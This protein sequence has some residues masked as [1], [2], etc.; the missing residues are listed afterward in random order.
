MRIISRQVDATCEAERRT[1]ASP[2]VVLG[3]HDEKPTATEVAR[4]YLRHEALS[5]YAFRYILPDE[6]LRPSC[7]CGETVRQWTAWPL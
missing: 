1:V 5:K 3:E 2:R 6:G 4:Q 7:P